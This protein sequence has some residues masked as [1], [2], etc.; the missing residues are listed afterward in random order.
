MNGHSYFGAAPAA[1][2]SDLDLSTFLRLLTVQLINQN[3]LEPMGDRDFFAQL[4]QLGQVQGMDK[5]QDSLDTSQAAALIGKTVTAVRP[6]TQ[7]GDV[8]DSMV[9]GVVE[10]IAVVNGQRILGLREADGGLV[11]VQIGNIREIA[12]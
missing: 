7:S 4:A 11:E 3:P 5:I 12:N 1:K 2:K 9:T 8:F 6:F 10:R